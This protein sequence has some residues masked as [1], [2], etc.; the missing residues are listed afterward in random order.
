[1]FSLDRPFR[2]A[3][4]R[5]LLLRVAIGVVWM[6]ASCGGLVALALYAKVPGPI[7]QSPLQ[8]PTDSK[9]VCDQP[10]ATLITF[11]HPKCPCT[12]ASLGELAKIVARF[13]GA[14]TP[15]VVFY[16]P[17]GSD[18]TW[19]RTDLWTT[20]AAIPGAKVVSDPDGVEARRFHAITSGHTLLYSARGTLLF[21]GGITQARG[22]AGDNTG[23]SAIESILAGETPTCNSTPVFGCPIVASPSQS[24]VA[25]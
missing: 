9:L 12:R 2:S 1:M 4:D 23:R 3:G 14:V 15:W 17:A 20:A 11:A 19:D 7:G 25:P 18:L 24:Q 13:Q 22:H 21:S 16:K 5:R 10:A 8:W 6:G